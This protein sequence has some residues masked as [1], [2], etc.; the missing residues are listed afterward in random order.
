MKASR[1]RACEETGIDDHDV[2]RPMLYPHDAAKVFGVHRDTFK[3]WVRNGRFNI[4]TERYTNG[5]RYDMEDV[6]KGAYPGASDDQIAQLMYQ[7]NQQKLQE[8]GE[9][10]LRRRGWEIYAAE[11]KEREEAAG[12]QEDVGQRI[13]VEP[14]SRQNPGDRLQRAL[15]RLRAGQRR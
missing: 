12:Q 11:E 3:K 4:R 8:R 10:R 2:D 6:F 1:T 7:F 5:T 9:M 14:G 15:E 13:R